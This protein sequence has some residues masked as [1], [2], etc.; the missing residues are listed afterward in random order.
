MPSRKKAQGKAR[1]AEQA[2]KARNNLNPNSGFGCHHIGERNWSQDDYDAAYSL[3]KEYTDKCNE[4]GRVGGE[5]LSNDIYRLA[6][7][8]YDEYHQLSDARK[9]LFQKL[10]LRRSKRQQS[11]QRDDHCRD[12]YSS[13][14]Y[15]NH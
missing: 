5:N 13:H 10:L 15:C 11:Y 2:A 1:K 12:T 3:W 9:E 8:T 6:Y 14:Y 4:I 7:N